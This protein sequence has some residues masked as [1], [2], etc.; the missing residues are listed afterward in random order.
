V[1]YIIL[2]FKIVPKSAFAIEGVLGRRAVFILEAFVGADIN[3]QLVVHVKVGPADKNAMKAAGIVR[4]V[5][6]ERSGGPL[7]HLS[8]NHVV[9]EVKGAAQTVS[10]HRPALLGYHKLLQLKIT[11]ISV[12][13]F[14]SG[15]L[16]SQPPLAVCLA[17]RIFSIPSRRSAAW[18][19]DGRVVLG[20]LTAGLFQVLASGGAPSPHDE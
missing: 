10:H 20:S 4:F 19:D 7:E 14:R 5:K 11:G 2:R 16:Y 13:P 12:L 8:V 3:M 17:S 18:T 1:H 6:R 15:L 9:R